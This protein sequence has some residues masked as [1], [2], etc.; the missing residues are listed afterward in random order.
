[1]SKVDADR[2]RAHA[3]A[4]KSFIRSRGV[5][6]GIILELCFDL[7]QQEKEE[8]KKKLLMLE[9]SI[10]LYICELRMP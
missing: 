8:E 10:S 9:H 1:M 4:C 6:Y 3:I 7:L 5:M 2:G